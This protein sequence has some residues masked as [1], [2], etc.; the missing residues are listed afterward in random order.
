LAPLSSENLWIV[1]PIYQDV[2]PFLRLREEIQQ[3]LG[4][5][6]G[7]AELAARFVALDDSAGQDAE[8]DLL[9]QFDDVSVVEP[10]FNLG[11]QRGLVY[12]LRRMAGEI[13]DN[14]I[15]VTL[16]SDGQDRPQDLPR[17]IAALGPPSRE[18]NIALALRTRRRSSLSF[19]VLYV[20]FR[21]MFRV[22]TGTTVRTGNFAA[23][24]GRIVTRVLAHPAFDLSYSATFLSLGLPLEYVP[25]P[26]GDRYAGRSRMGRS[27]LVLHGLRMLMPFADRIAMRALVVFAATLVVSVVMMLAVLGV[28][29]F[30]DEA[31]PGWATYTLIGL[32]TL[33]LIAAGNFVT[34]FSVFS[35]SRAISLAHLEEVTDSDQPAGVSSRATG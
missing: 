15:V 1:A 32:L 26:R 8:V 19:K 24:R 3:V 21:L 29:L 30:T 27:R 12:A 14:D 11:H 16:D 31:I 5:Q 18:P 9:R 25:C 6:D 7:R 2:Q 33:S 34:L 20:S 4:A 17:L 13:A 35:Q 23:Y 10:P 28:K 22:L